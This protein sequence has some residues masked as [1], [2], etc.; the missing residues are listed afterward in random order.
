MGVW[1]AAV[2]VVDTRGLTIVSGLDTKRETISRAPMTEPSQVPT[3]AIDEPLLD[4]HQVAALLGRSF[5][6]FC[7]SR[8]Q[9][10]LRAQGF[11]RPVAGTKRY[12]PAAIRAWRLK[13]MDPKLRAIVAEE[14]N[15]DAGR[16]EAHYGVALSEAAASIGREF[17]KAG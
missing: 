8:T 7:H 9:K 17:A 3:A 5:T 12:D 15:R 4:H 6:W 2:S 10:R 11:P 14:A 16:V 13:Q 1:Y